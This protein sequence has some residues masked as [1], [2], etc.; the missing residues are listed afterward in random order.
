MPKTPAPAA[1]PERMFFFGSLRDLDLLEIVIGRAPHGLALADGHLEDHAV[2]CVAGEPFPMLVAREGAR[3]HG[4]LV[5]GLGPQ[6]V[7]RI[8]FYEDVDYAL[9][10]VAVHAEG[11]RVEAHAYLALETLTDSG[12][13]W[14]LVRWQAEEKAFM[15]L[16]AEEMMRFHGVLSH[17]EV[18][19]RWPAIKAR[20]AARLEAA[21]RPRRQATR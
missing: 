5:E 15:L 4:L 7:D 13:P 11:A 14:D 18:D 17:A 16:C 9:S 6:E 2:H 20:A 19:A 10:P 3:A 1:H 12:T 8:S 21:T